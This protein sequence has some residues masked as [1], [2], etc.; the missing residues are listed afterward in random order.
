MGR[1]DYR[2]RDTKK[3]KKDAKKLAPLTILPVATNVEVGK[4]EKR[5]SEVEEEGE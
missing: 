4:K 1:R 3:T 2:H 5:K